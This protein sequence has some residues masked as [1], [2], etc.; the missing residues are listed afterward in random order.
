MSASFSFP[1][2]SY[3]L[4]LSLSTKVAI[5]RAVKVGYG[6]V[7]VK[8]RCR[9]FRGYRYILRKDCVVLLARCFLSFEARIV[10]ER[11]ER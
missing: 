10:R 9:F 11:R 6:R 7:L 2:D 1:F 3:V 5:K 4:S 8:K